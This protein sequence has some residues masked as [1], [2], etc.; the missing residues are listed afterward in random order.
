MRWYRTLNSPSPPL[1]YTPSTFVC[2]HSGIAPYL[3]GRPIESRALAVKSL[4]ASS[5][6]TNAPPPSVVEPHS[7]VQESVL[8]CERWV[9]R[10]EI[11]L[12]IVTWI[13]EPTTAAGANK[14]S[15][16]SPRSTLRCSTN[17]PQ[18]RPDQHTRQRVNQSRGSP[19]IS[20]ST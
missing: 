20:S 3:A 19:R 18:P 11:R 13:D 12:A 4:R 7:L 14:P 5:T 6:N 9:T 1:L 17:Q 10:D 2:W 8:D 16:C 15:D